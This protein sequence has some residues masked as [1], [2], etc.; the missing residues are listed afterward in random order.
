MPEDGAVEAGGEV[1]RPAGLGGGAG[2]AGGAAAGPADPH[3]APFAGRSGQF[4]QDRVEVGAVTGEE[5]NLSRPD[6]DEPD[7]P[8]G[9]LVPYGERVGRNGLA[10]GGR[11]GLA[12]GGRSGSCPAGGGRGG[13][14]RRADHD[15]SE[16]GVEV[17]TQGADPLLAG[18]IERSAV[19]Q[20]PGQLGGAGVG[21]AGGGTGGQLP[22]EFGGP[23][24]R[25]GQAGQGLEEPLGLGAVGAFGPCTGTCIGVGVGVGGRIEIEDGPAEAVEETVDLLP[26]PGTGQ[27]QVRQQQGVVGPARPLLDAPRMATRPVRRRFVVVGEETGCPEQHA[28]GDGRGVVAE[29]AG[30]QAG[31][32]EVE[33]VEAEDRGRPPLHQLVAQGLVLQQASGA[34]G[35]RAGRGPAGGPVVAQEPAQLARPPDM[36]VAVVVDP[37]PDD[38]VPLGVD[39]LGHEPAVR[40]VGG[41]RQNGELVGSPAPPLR[42]EALGHR[43]GVGGVGDAQALLA[44]GQAGAEERR[45]DGVALFRPPVEDADVLPVIE[46]DAG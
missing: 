44:P 16:G 38:R 24:M 25:S 23:Q 9:Q 42:V 4:G 27:E 39:A 2:G 1:G 28:P 35:A 14:R 13:H 10:G 40:E 15:G 6:G 5:G 19:E 33:V 12:G 7:A 3:D 45:Q 34:V 41:G 46:R 20:A 18:G 32:E 26:V 36:P 17:E 37:G 21:S 31:V 22:F 30:Q 8:G 29:D 11:N 43:P